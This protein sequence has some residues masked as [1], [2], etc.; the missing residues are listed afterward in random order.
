MTNKAPTTL[1]AIQAAS[2]Y[3]F[4]SAQIVIS[5]NNKNKQ[6]TLLSQRKLALTTINI[7]LAL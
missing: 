5:G 7:L 6:L 1:S 2:Q 4:I 3:T